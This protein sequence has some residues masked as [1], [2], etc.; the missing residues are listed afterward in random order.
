MLKTK[1]LIL[2]LLTHVTFQTLQFMTIAQTKKYGAP[3]INYEIAPFGKFPYGRELYGALYYEKSAGCSSFNLPKSE[4]EFPRMV[5]LEAGDCNIKIKAMNAERANVELLIIIRATAQSHFDISKKTDELVNMMVDIPTIT[6][7]NNS[8]TRLK[9]MLRTEDDVFLK[10]AMPIPQSKNVY[11]D[12]YVH[13]KDEKIFSFLKNIKHQI[14]QFDNVVKIQFHF[15]KPENQDLKLTQDRAS[16]EIMMNCL[17]YD[18]IFD[19]MGIYKSLCLDK[20]IYTSSCFEDVI[21]TLDSK[22]SQDFDIC[23]NNNLPYVNTTIKSM[24][25]DNRNTSSFIMINGKTY[26][27]SMKPE[28]VFEAICGAFETSPQ[29]CLFLNNKYS[30]FMHYSE[31]QRRG[32]AYRYFVYLMNFIVLVG[33]LALAGVAIYVLYNKI[34]SKF[35]EENVATIVK[36]SMSNYHSIKNN[37]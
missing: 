6:I 20:Q 28:N 14:I 32:K 30:V 33:L 22:T 4:S 18:A 1:I 5:L 17:D 29:S 24:K 23:K 21:N 11:V 2:T 27:G 34:Y 35:L 12:I 16:L 10:F 19:S 13:Q 36:E 9:S 37:E 15:F 7:D 26:H 3:Q 25:V 8:G 31:Y